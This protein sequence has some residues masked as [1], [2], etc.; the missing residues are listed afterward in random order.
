[1]IEKFS[2]VES[3]LKHEP[4]SN[5]WITG[6]SSNTIYVSGGLINILIVILNS[7]EQIHYSPDEVI[8]YV[9][10]DGVTFNTFSIIITNIT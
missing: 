8:F 7:T 6:N 5:G 3:V 10:L 1:M 2:E 4:I 9:I